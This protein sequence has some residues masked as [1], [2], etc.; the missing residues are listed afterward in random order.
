MFLL[1]RCLNKM[2]AHVQCTRPMMNL[3]T[4]NTSAG[5]VTLLQ[6]LH[7]LGDVFRL[8]YHLVYPYLVEIGCNYCPVSQSVNESR[9]HTIR[10]SV[11]GTPVADLR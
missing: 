8:I 5:L 10:I 1:L 9:I 3:P 2:L 6:T 7:Q 4:S 11:P